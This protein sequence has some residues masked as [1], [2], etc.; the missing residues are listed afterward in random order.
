MVFLHYY[1]YHI[2]R[3]CK[4]KAIMTIFDKVVME[5]EVGMNSSCFRFVNMF[6]S[7]DLD[8]VYY[9]WTCLWWQL[10]IIASHAMLKQLVVN[11]DLSH[12]STCIKM[13]MMWYGSMVF[14]SEKFKW[15]GLAH[16]QTCSWF[17]T[18]AAFMMFKFRVFISYSCYVQC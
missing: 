12:R 14:P 17:K 10:E 9:E 15:Y 3:S 5:K 13:V 1:Y 8:S 2:I 7:F 4:W 6:S 18:N 16:V 11:N